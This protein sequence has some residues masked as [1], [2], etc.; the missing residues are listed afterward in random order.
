MSAQMHSVGILP[1]QSRSLGLGAAG[2]GGKSFD[3]TLLWIGTSWKMNKTLGEGLV[4]VET[5]LR[6]LPSIDRRLQPFIAPPF[7]AL[8]EVK[9]AL[10]S[11]AVKVGAQNMHWEDT[12]AWTGEISPLMLADCG[13]DFVELGHYERRRYF[14]ETNHTVGLKTAAAVRHGIRPLVCVGETLAEREDGRAEDVLREQ[15]TAALREVDGQAQSVDIMFAYEPVWAI[16]E[17]GSPA[18]P[19]Y[20]DRQH[21][22][23]KRVARDVLRIELRVLYGGSVNMANA[24]EFINMRN[25]DGLFIGRSAW[26][27][28]NYIELMG[29]VSESLR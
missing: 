25:I 20:A 5:L 2:R 14:G 15:V 23:I 13:A 8:R 27:A 18:D 21:E 19:N 1:K 7:T 24:A 4:Y 28:G 26:N 11:S 12:G 3:M 29:K 17:R 6:A 10:S 9:Q 16:G 22:L